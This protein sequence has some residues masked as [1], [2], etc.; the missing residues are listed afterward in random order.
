MTNSFPYAALLLQVNESKYNTALTVLVYILSPSSLPLLQ[1]TVCG[2]AG[3]SGVPAQPAVVRGNRAPPDSSC[4][5]AS[6]EGRHVKDLSTAPGPAWP[7][8]VV[9][10]KR[11]DR[12]RFI[13][14]HK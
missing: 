1:W 7:L 9:S 3:P 13:D 4:S 2:P 14:H 10:E 11:E 6:M 5:P 8:T 12:A